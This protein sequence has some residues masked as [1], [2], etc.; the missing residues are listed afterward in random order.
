M[1]RDELKYQL[2]LLKVNP[3]F[4][5]LDGELLPDRMVIYNSYKEWQVF[6]FDE[7]GNRNSIKTFNSEDKACKCLYDH[8]ITHNHF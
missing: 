1:T 5:S 4:Y 8:F 3:N 7:R 2:D 6:Y